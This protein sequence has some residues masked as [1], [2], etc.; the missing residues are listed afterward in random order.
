MAEEKDHLRLEEWHHTCGDGCCDSW[1]VDLYINDV[2][3]EQ[4]F[5]DTTDALKHYLSLQGV[6]V[7]DTYSDDDVN[8]DY[9]VDD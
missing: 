8:Y 4:N 2:L 1:G 9:W 7:E 3:V 5:I 6:T